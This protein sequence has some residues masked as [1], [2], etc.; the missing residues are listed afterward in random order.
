MLDNSDGPLDPHLRTFSTN[1]LRNTAWQVVLGDARA[2][3]DD[4][5]ATI[6]PARLED[7]AGL[8]P[9]YLE[10]GYLRTRPCLLL[11]SDSAGR[12]R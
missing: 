12:W 6:V 3:A 7:A 10:V 8:P 1:T 4:A 9:A 2:H 5:P 11:R